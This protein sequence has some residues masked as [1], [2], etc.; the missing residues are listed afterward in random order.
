MNLIQ[1]FLTKNPCYTCGRTIT[2]YRADA[3]FRR[4]PPTVRRRVREEL[5][6]G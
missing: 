5:E 4:M 6:P 2:P 1:S 3:S